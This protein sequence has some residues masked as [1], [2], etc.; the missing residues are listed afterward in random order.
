MEQDNNS[1]GQ[2]SGLENAN[3]GVPEWV[4]RRPT[5]ERGILGS[6]EQYADIVKG[7][8]TARAEGIAKDGAAI[9]DAVGRAEKKIIEVVEKVS[10][11]AES[12]VKFVGRVFRGLEGGAKLIAE[13]SGAAM[14]GLAEDAVDVAAGT[15]KATVEGIKWTGI[16]LAVVAATPFVL[17][18]G[19]AMGGVELVQKGAAKVGEIRAGL[20]EWAMKGVKAGAAA[21]EAKALAEEIRMAGVKDTVSEQHKG[22]LESIQDKNL[23]RVVIKKVRNR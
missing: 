21:V 20:W 17:A 5:A 13:E 4:M 2:P 22:R 11:V 19:L 9:S 1:G 12:G 10:D 14:K 23:V 18:E 15:A 8:E 7:L 3:V 16:G 6:A